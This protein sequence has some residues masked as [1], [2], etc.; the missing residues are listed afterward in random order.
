MGK[1]GSGHCDGQKSTCHHHIGFSK[2]DIVESFNERM[3]R[4]GTSTDHSK[5]GSSESMAHGDVSS[6]NV[7]DH[8]RYEKR[9]EPWGSI[10]FCIGH[11][12]FLKSKQASNSTGKN[13]ARPVWIDIVL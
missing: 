9:I 3:G 11:H 12:F 4:R 1:E 8:L 10:T 2:L 6:S 7:K 5:I 13:Y